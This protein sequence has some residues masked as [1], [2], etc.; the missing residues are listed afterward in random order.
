MDETVEAA[1]ARLGLRA[2]TLLEP[3]RWLAVA[4]D[5]AGHQVELQAMDA[6][7]QDDALVARVARLRGLRHDHLVRLLDATELTPGRIGLLVE[8]VEGLSLAQ[9]RA[10]RA[11]LTD[12][13][14]AT[15]TIPVAGALGALHDAALSHGAVDATTILVR[16]DGRPVLC[17]L[18]GVVVGG[19]A[20]RDDLVAL[21][22]AVVAQLP[23][24]DVHLLAGGLVLRDAL[25]EAL[26]H[27]SIDAA[28]LAQACVRA[29]EPEPVQ[30]PDAGALASLALL[31]SARH[32]PPVA[33]RRSSRRRFP[34]GLVALGCVAVLALG[35]VGWRLHSVPASSPVTDAQDPVHAAVELSRLRAAAVG[36][37]DEAGLGAVEVADSPAR[38]ADSTLLVSIDPARAH[39]LVADVQ[40]AW[41]VAD[42]G[43]RGSTTD[44]AVTSA[45]SS[46]TGVGAPRTVV[47]GLRWTDDGW[48]VWD[49][50]DPAG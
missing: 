10:A 45:M 42:D 46:A 39:G 1:L 30:L 5:G 17:D 15:V 20:P 13:E 34:T 24:D 6:D 4:L 3:D 50:K 44:V 49:V 19:S 27:P 21:A 7:V 47:L 32:A 38:T 48:R 29:A 36:A 22:S 25:A 9:I 28:G 2:T 33:T 41:L 35:T 12:G 31:S 16:P 14:A 8:H 37:G 11:P 23:G 18:R 26:G 40:D 43:S